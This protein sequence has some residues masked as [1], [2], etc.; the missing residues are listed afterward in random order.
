MEEDER[1]RP[2]RIR[3]RA[4]RRSGRRL[5]R[6]GLFTIEVCRDRR[7]KGKGGLTTPP[8]RLGCKR[9]AESLSASGVGR[10]PLGGRSFRRTLMHPSM[11]RLVWRGG[12]ATLSEVDAL[13]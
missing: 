3:R 4:K 8:T 1:D 9:L 7:E 13:D 6:G 11:L 5:A 10:S 2:R 12:L